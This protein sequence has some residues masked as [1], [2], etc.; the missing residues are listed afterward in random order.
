MNMNVNVSL[1]SPNATVELVDGDT[2]TRPT[3]LV[4]LPFPA[5]QYLSAADNV[6]EPIYRL[7]TRKARG[8][9]I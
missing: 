7:L 8:T 3:P 1:V 9:T 2:T 6:E 4:P 5:A